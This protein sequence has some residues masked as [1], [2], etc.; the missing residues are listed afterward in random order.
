MKFDSRLDRNLGHLCREKLGES[1]LIVDSI[2]SFTTNLWWKSTFIRS[3]H[4]SVFPLGSTPPMQNALYSPFVSRLNPKDV[5]L[6]WAT[7]PFIWWERWAESGGLTRCELKR[8]SFGCLNLMC[9]K[10]VDGSIFISL[11]T[12]PTYRQNKL[13]SSVCTIIFFFFLYILVNRSL[14]KFGSVRNSTLLKR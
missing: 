10:R 11:L 5:G 3:F 4:S 9:V 12:W 2:Y 8:P 6:V 14:R 7:H 13:A 1:I